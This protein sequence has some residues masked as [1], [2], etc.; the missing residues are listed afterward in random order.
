MTGGKI[1]VSGRSDA[2]FALARYNPNGSL[3]T[4]FGQGGKVT[5]KFGGG[6]VKG[7]AITEDGKV[8]VA[9]GDGLHAILMRY[10]TDGTL[11]TTFGGDGIV[12]TDTDDL[13]QL[14]SL[15]IDSEGR[16]V[17]A[18][19][20]IGEGEGFEVLDFAVARFKPDG[21]LDT[22]FGSNGV[23]TTD[24][25]PNAFDGAKA[26]AVADDG[27]ILAAGTA[28]PPFPYDDSDV[29]LVRYESDGS[30]DIS[31]DG[32]GIVT[33]D[34]DAGSEDLD[35]A[36]AVALED[37]DV[38]VGGHA[39]GDF[40]LARYGPD[41]ALDPTFGDQG[42]VTTTIG[43]T[44]AVNA[45]AI[46][47]DGRVVTAGESDGD[48]AVAR[49]NPDGSLDTS[50]AVGG[51]GIEDLGAVD[52]AVSV[53]VTGEGAVLLAGGTTGAF[54]LVK[55]T[56]EGNLD[57]DFDQDGVALTP[58]TRPSVDQV[59]GM[60]LG[61]EGK[62]VEV[63]STDAD[64]G[65][66]FSKAVIA[67]YNSDGSLDTSFAGDG[68]LVPEIPAGF[69]RSLSAV[70]VEPDGR[71][72]A[73]GQHEFNFLV[74]R[75]N[76]DGTADTSFGG[77]GIVISPSSTGSIGGATA[78]V[79][80]GDG[81]V[82]VVGN[83]GGGQFSD[84]LIGRYNA[85]G[86]PDTSFGGD[87]F[88]STD[89]GA[90]QFD[91]ATAIAMVQ[92]D[93]ILV[94]GGG[95][96]AS[97]SF[98]LARYN[99]DGSLDTSFGGDGVATYDV[100]S[101]V[102]TTSLAIDGSGRSV[103]AGSSGGDA[104]LA[105]LSSDGTL[106]SSFGGDGFVLTDLGGSDTARSVVVDSESR[107]VLSGASSFDFA[108]AR[109]NTD[110]TL[111]SAFGEGGISTLDVGDGSDE[112]G[113]LLAI[114]TNG[115]LVAGGDSG[116]DFAVARLQGT[117]P[118]RALSV[119]TA[120]SGGGTVT[121]TGI[122][123]PD[124]CS[125]AYVE[126]TVITLTAEPNDVSTFA[127]WSGSGCS[128]TGTCEVTLNESTAVTADFDYEQRVTSDIS[129]FV[130][131]EPIGMSARLDGSVLIADVNAH[132]ILEVTE[133]GS[134]SVVAGTGAQGSTG[135][136]G[137]ATSA[138]LRF[139]QGV[140]ALPDGGFLIADTENRK[141]RRVSSSGIISTV[142]GNSSAGYVSPDGVQA[143]TVNLDQPT[144]VEA[145]SDNGF[146]VVERSEHR[147]REV[148]PDGTIWTVAGK[149][150]SGF[151]GDG[152]PATSAK[153][154]EPIDVARMA[155]GGFL[156]ADSENNRVRKVGPAGTIS[157]FA[158]TG[159]YDFNGDGDKASLADLSFY[160]G[161]API[162]GGVAV[163]SDGGV[164]IAD[165]HNNR[166]RFV[167]PTGS[168]TTIAGTGEPGADGDG[169]PAM[170]A[171]ITLP[172]R[173]EIAR[174][175][176][177]ISQQGRVRLVDKTSILSGPPA[178]VTDPEAEISFSF[179]SWYHGPDFECKL[180]GEAFD[181]CDSPISYEGLSEDTHT[182]V[183]R[184]VDGD[185]T[186]PTPAER[187]FAVDTA[188]PDSSASSEDPDTTDWPSYRGGP[189]QN[190]NRSSDPGTSPSE[191]WRT[192][193]SVQ[194]QQCVAMADGHLFTMAAA[195]A[196]FGS[197][198]LYRI[199]PADGA[200]V[201][202]SSTFPYS[203]EASCPAADS[204][205][206]YAARGTHLVAWK[207][208]DGSVEWDADLGSSVGSPVV[209]GE[210]VF[211]NA[212]GSIYAREA[213]T[214]APLWSEARSS[215]TLTPP[216]LTPT[217]AVNRL[218]GGLEAFRL[219]NGTLRW[220]LSDEIRDVITVGDA[221]IYTTGIVG[222]TPAEVVSVSAL[223]G[224][225][226][227]SHDL[228]TFTD[229]SR[230][231]AGD[232]IVYALA[233]SHD[234]RFQNNHLVAL[235]VSDGA[236]VYEQDFGSVSSC[237]GTT[238]G[239]PPFVKF[240]DRL[241]N[242]YRFFDALSGEAPGGPFG[243]TQ[244]VFY[245]SMDCANESDSVFANSGGT[246]YGWANTCGTYRLMARRDTTAPL[247]FD[248]TAPLNGAV[249][250]TKRP[251]LDWN[252]AEDNSGGTGISHYEV[253]LDGELIDDDVD[254]QVT[255]LTPV[256]D[257]SE[258]THAWAV[259]AVDPRGNRR[260]SGSHSFVVDS[261]PPDE[262]EPIDPV[263]GAQALPR[264]VA[265][266]W[267][268]ASDAGTDIEYELWIDGAVE[269]KLAADDCGPD[270]CSLTISELLEGGMHDWHVRAVDAAENSRSS[271]TRSFTVDASPPQTTI[272]S[273]PSG[274][275]ANASPSFAFS[276]E[277]G[278][279]FQCKLDG[280]SFADCTSPK[281]YTSLPD[282]SH[283]F[284]VRAIDAAGNADPTPATRS[285]TVD[286]SPPD[287]FD[288]TTPAD[289]A[290]VKSPR[291]ELG[292]EA[293]FDSIA[294]LD[295]YV[296]V[297]DG[298]EIA[299]FPPGIESHLIA[300]DLSP[301]IHTWTVKARDTLGNLQAAPSRTFIV[302][303]AP[304]ADL[305]VLPIPALTNDVVTFNATGSSPPVAGSN[306]VYEWD[307]DG[308][309]SFET[310]TGST[311][312]ATHT[313]GVVTSIIAT[314]RITSSFGTTA[315]DSAPV[316]IRPAPGSGE[317]GVTINNGAQYTNDTDVTI[318]TVWPR[319]SS[320]A[321]VSNDGGF[322][323]PVQQPV[324]NE[325]PW[326]LESSGPERLPKTIYVRFRSGTTNSETY[327]DDIILDQTAPEVLEASIDGGASASTASISKTRRTKKRA[328]V[329]LI[330]AKDNVSGVLSAQ[331][332]QGKRKP[333]RWQ[334]F[335][336]HVALPGRFGR[337]LV[338]VRDRAGNI[339]KW[340]LAKV[341]QKERGRR[342]SK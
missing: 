167:S 121:G 271:A 308:N 124:D 150:Q 113:A 48:F 32:D 300:D 222:G 153:L 323:A 149:L 180:D 168:I 60:A 241:Y 131:A 79:L 162:A 317:P 174:E 155:G 228:P 50:F 46:D 191:A 114:Q 89:L 169:G 298:I 83:N 261:I 29:A 287:I 327:T 273:G 28:A 6:A 67:R 219:S 133:A 302:P 68:I 319:F 100:G 250:A 49:Y 318:S 65:T 269:D 320:T 126:G 7:M 40:L 208:A 103:V 263:D 214:G 260:S 301:G 311:S 206:V 330:R 92:G 27:D 289:N 146:Y 69:F 58:F 95:G 62:I 276:S 285:F 221:L 135:D 17:G 90:E 158:G 183:V 231:V 78:V 229:G 5:T 139:P 220:S 240:G 277:P 41:G 98:A 186:D 2:S 138:K 189:T 91:I 163:T 35:G 211:V 134:V 26:I 144:D 31:F 18:G 9:G 109:Y 57:Q 82:I 291:P 290:V 105:R 292:W 120:G 267:E 224:S 137:Q 192:L 115:M 108:F 207:V 187:T 268:R 242:H 160:D 328:A 315:T 266:S 14:N 326:T 282:G 185:G 247:Q 246:I 22:S 201:W 3:D 235:N 179:A 20:A 45:L 195:P 312:S 10:N 111:D 265:F 203:G 21:S 148:E 296:L 237:C 11:D 253:T 325:I 225:V 161:I 245:N 341:R 59:R 307:L 178:V 333:G 199:D 209:R 63:G 88:V 284:E 125:D 39:G 142:A 141:V 85:D 19:T 257:V 288:L 177:L 279:T 54:G 112:S 118:V 75:F 197:Q 122:D 156:I 264:K 278:A 66:G 34:V 244:T 322:L 251:L 293:T 147:V 181:P 152:G 340:R 36:N 73:V 280:E 182:F 173:V 136:G 12:E 270:V 196:D 165:T 30:L 272:D 324:A 171:T 309:G 94:T 331:V 15:S 80:S 51:I 140:E 86:S 170:E 226:N 227:W 93:K 205:L 194:W 332:K 99:S 258:G 107:P 172:R 297:V 175:G 157:T 230:L 342:K 249:S 212:G 313:Y 43:T 306:A 305:V 262:F 274:L 193:S 295:I 184:A 259:D 52:Q 316:D 56:Q 38:I 159:T 252:A 213:A 239:Y 70:A 304:I 233:P 25:S 101:F 190:M 283:S 329:L 303:S 188:P 218:S 210:R 16:V 314:V 127:G 129:T 13:N 87:G 44:G 299:Q 198:R 339:S 216:L 24:I 236:L 164:A 248:V 334:A 97:V 321:L 154:D 72:V 255:E 47:E 64:Q 200:T 8:V 84:F 281:P 310:N 335:K 55:Y 215:M 176:L 166:V 223:D 33:T 74:A 256:A 143:T 4:S 123:C 238:A 76:S 275:T 202:S 151:G 336:S 106:D 42:L 145:T 110:G 61:P 102:S 77:D 204:T 243:T 130:T 119:N 337:I 338:R 217:A 132:R 37:E 232:G 234:F 1:V 53:H 116:G 104:T 294:G 71:I 96:D 128:G 286:A 23:V 254:P 117:P 81:K